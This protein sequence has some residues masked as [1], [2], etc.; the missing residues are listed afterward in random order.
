MPWR[1]ESAGILSR[2]LG[3]RGNCSSAPQRFG[4]AVAKI[5][6]TFILFRVMVQFGFLE[7]AL[8]GEFQK[9]WSQSGL[10]PVTLGG[11]HPLPA[12]LTDYV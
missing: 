8:A 12:L 3:F 9:K 7:F 5:W 6:K 4:V 2:R 11:D 10:V 1:S